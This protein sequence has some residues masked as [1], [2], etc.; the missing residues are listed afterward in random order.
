MTSKAGELGELAVVEM[1]IRPRILREF[2]GYFAVSL[3]A[4]AVD[5]GLFSF[6]LRM[7]R[8]PWF[9]AATLGFTAGV[10]L[11]YWLS[12]RLVF[13]ERRLQRSPRVELAS[14]ILVGVAGLGVTQGVLW[15]GIDLLGLVPEWCKLAA[16]GFTFIFNFGIRKLMLFKC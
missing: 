13:V 4:L 2:L 15:C 11:A 6:C 7:L 14:F 3:L 10:L 8:L 12:V 9:H 1:T 5:F 16:A